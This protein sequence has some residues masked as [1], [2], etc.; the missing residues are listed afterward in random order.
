MYVGG[1]FVPKGT[2]FWISLY[3]MQTL[4]SLYDEPIA[5][6]PVFP[7]KLWHMHNFSPTKAFSVQALM[8]FLFPSAATDMLCETPV[9][10]P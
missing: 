8:S 5:F 3:A 6:K 10:G 2:V 4:S 7:V 9:E 1:Y